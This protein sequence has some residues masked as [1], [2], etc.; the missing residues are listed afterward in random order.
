LLPCRIPCFSTRGGPHGGPRGHRSYLSLLY[1]PGPGTIYRDVRK[2]EPGHWLDW[3]AGRGWRKNRYWRPVYQPKTGLTEGEA[4]EQLGEH[5]ETAVRD[6][7]E[8]EVPLG[9]F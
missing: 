4:V 1:V 3:A 5:L 8:S 9:P 2:L 6:R 7:L